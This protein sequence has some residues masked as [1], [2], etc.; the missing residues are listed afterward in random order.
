MDGIWK[1]P[2]LVDVW[3]AG[4][5]GRRGDGRRTTVVCQAGSRS[6]APQA[7]WRATHRCSSSWPVPN[8]GQSQDSWSRARRLLGQQPTV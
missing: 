3:A 6:R 4:P 8:T 7:C 2:R 5:R 1:L